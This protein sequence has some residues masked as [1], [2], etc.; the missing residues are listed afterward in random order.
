METAEHIAALRENGRLLAEA[1]RRAGLDAPVPSCPDWRVRD[2]VAHIGGVHRW[3][4]A[5]VAEGRTEPMDAAT[6]ARYRGGAPADADLLDWFADG[7]LAL[8][9]ALEQAPPGLACWTFFPAASPLAF[10][11]RRQSHETAIHR[12]DT[13]LAAAPGAGPGAVTE[14]DAALAADGIDELLSGFLTHRGRLRADPSRTLAVHTTDTGDS[15]L[16]RVE[17]DRVATH[18]AAAP[19]ADCTLGGRSA[20][21]YLLLWNRIGTENVQVTG[22]PSVLDL[23]RTGA[24]I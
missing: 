2:L 22:D 12:I 21:L 14:P 5:F 9:R 8:V 7:H 20:A 6:R 17:P 13:E 10:W 18:R 1:A 3:A 23:W 15:W 24:V 11:S 4:T 19:A 16:V